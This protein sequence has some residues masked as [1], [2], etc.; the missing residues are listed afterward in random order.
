[1][2]NTNTQQQQTTAN[3]R[4]KLVPINFNGFIENNLNKV[5][6]HLTTYYPYPKVQ[7]FN[8]CLSLTSQGELLISNSRPKEPI[9]L[10]NN[11]NIW[12]HHLSYKHWAWLILYQ[13]KK[14][15]K[16][17]LRLQQNY[18]IDD[19]N[20]YLV[21]PE[22]YGTF[23]TALFTQHD[24]IDW[25]IASIIKPIKVNKE[26]I[27]RDLTYFANSLVMHSDY[28]KIINNN[29]AIRIIKDIIEYSQ[30]IDTPQ[31]PAFLMLSH[32]IS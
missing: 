17:Q 8:S 20:K 29:N 3:M 7:V 31:S 27:C 15:L 32:I 25:I 24:Y 2:L 13:Y 28:N 1:M 19:C 11:L 18:T 4:L 23:N 14:W 10:N 5:I 9:G 22:E 16:R 21:I 26:F 30:S 12:Y 6:D